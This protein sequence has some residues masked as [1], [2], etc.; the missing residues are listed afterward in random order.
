MYEV[1]FFPL[2]MWQYGTQN[3]IRSQNNEC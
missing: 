1:S 2:N 3:D